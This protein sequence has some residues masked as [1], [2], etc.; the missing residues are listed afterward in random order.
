MSKSWMRPREEQ[1]ALAPPASE[2]DKRA[3][4]WAEITKQIRNLLD[5]KLDLEKKMRDE[6][7]KSHTQVYSLPVDADLNWREPVIVIKTGM[8]NQVVIDLMEVEFSGILNG[9]NSKRHAKGSKF[10]V[11]RSWKKGKT[12]GTHYLLYDKKSKRIAN[13]YG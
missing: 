10:T 5:E 13:F 8:T 7:I 2:D 11:L 1:K 4:R 3:V 9:R 6:F 12:K